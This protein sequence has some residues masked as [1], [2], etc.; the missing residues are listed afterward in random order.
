MPGW[1]SEAVIRASV[2]NRST[3][4]G[5][6]V[7]SGRRIFTATIRASRMSSAT[8]TSPMPPTAIRWVE[9]VPAGQQHAGA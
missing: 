9:P 1:F 6:P 2:R 5:S 4:S 7:S 8:Q 3:N